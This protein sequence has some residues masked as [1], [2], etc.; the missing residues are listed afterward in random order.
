MEAFA[1]ATLPKQTIGTN[2]TALP[3]ST[4][5]K[6]Q[7]SAVVLKFHLIILFYL[8]GFVIQVKQ[9]VTERS[10]TIEARDSVM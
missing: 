3:T 7:V 8:K 1:G 6:K 2:V 10:S 9:T 5:K 4:Q